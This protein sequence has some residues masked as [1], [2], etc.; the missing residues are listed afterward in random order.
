TQKRVDVTVDRFALVDGTIAL[1]DR[2]LPEQRTWAS[3]NIHIEAHNVSTLRDDGTVVA[4]SV[5]A[6]A[7]NRVEIGEFRLYPIHLRAK[8]TGTGLA[9]ALA[10][11]YLPRDAPVLLDRDVPARSS[12]SRSMRA[13]RSVPTCAASSRIWC[14]SNP[15]SASP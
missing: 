3:E 5:T 12:T 2:A 6:G 13:R 7:P 4:S 9:L 8:V 1:E 15:A 14:W 10:R 11:L